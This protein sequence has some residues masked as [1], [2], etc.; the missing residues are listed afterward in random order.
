MAFLLGFSAHRC[1][2]ISITK[3]LYFGV[4]D[5]SKRNSVLI[6][7]DDASILLEL[8]SILKS[9]YKIL[10]VK[11][12]ESALEV[13]SEFTPDLIL[14]DVLMPDMDGYEVL[15]RLKRT[16]KTKEIPVIFITGIKAEDSGVNWSSIGAVDYI[17]KPFDGLDVRHR[18]RE[19]LCRA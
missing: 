13:A 11:D 2:G 6:V 5:V 4:I 12:G 17:N 9:E 19:Q 10:V 7:D 14:L 8:N 15:R 1:V 3:E 16:D 18:V